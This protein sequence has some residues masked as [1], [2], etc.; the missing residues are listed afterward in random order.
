L[1]SGL[2]VAPFSLQLRR[3]VPPGPTNRSCGGTSSQ[4]W[5]SSAST[6]S[7]SGD[8]K[9]GST[10]CPRFVAAASSER[11][12]SRPE[13]KRRCCKGYLSRSSIAGIRCAALLTAFGVHPRV[14]MRILRHSQIS[15]TMDVYTQ[16]PSPETCKALDRLNKRLTTESD[17]ALLL[18][19]RPSSRGSK[20]GAFAELAIG[21]EWCAARYASP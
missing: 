15:M 17:P 18:I 2:S 13:H 1:L 21:R 10:P 14:A 7:P 8:R 6:R 12:T 16:I 11:I 3:P 19:G 9:P 5:L 4:A 20:T